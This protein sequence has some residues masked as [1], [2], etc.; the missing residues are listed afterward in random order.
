MNQSGP[1]RYP[2]AVRGGGSRAQGLRV[3]VVGDDLVAGVG[4]A[5]SLGWVGRV[6]ARTPREET[7]VSLFP[8][9]VPDETTA[10]LLARWRE[11]SDRRFAGAALED[12]RLVLGLGPHHVYAGGSPPPA[13]P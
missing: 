11:E 13:P 2:V 7:L 3:C 5:R 4:D 6:G 8:L 9:G 12:C 1:E 10:G